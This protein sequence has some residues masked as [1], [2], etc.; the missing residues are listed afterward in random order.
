ME[1]GGTGDLHGVHGQEFSRLPL[2]PGGARVSMDSTSGG[3]HGLAL[4]EQKGFD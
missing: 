1:I 2:H 4:D 3:L